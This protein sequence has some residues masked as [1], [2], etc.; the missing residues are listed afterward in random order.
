MS[1]ATKPNKE[2]RIGRLSVNY[3]RLRQQLF[4]EILDHDWLNAKH[5]LTALETCDKQIKE[6][7]EKLNGSTE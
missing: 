4:Y 1:A 5:T 2:S 7:R 6:E 3:T